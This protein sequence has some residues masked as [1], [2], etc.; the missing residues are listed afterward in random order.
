MKFNKLAI[1]LLCSCLCSAFEDGKLTFLEKYPR[2]IPNCAT[3][4]QGRTQWLKFEI[5]L[6]AKIRAFFGEVL[7]KILKILKIRKSK[8]IWNFGEYREPARKHQ[9]QNPEMKCA[10]NLL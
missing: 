9:N 2:K 7:E 6:L 10:A 3:L 8:E 5:K 4:S 1:V